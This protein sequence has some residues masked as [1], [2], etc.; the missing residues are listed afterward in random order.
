MI[1]CIQGNR[2]LQDL[3]DRFE[4]CFVEANPGCNGNDVE[5]AFLNMILDVMLKKK[6]GQDFAETMRNR[7][8]A[9]R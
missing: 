5:R 2:V 7:I 9:I 4:F 3:F 1:L 8:E 6:P